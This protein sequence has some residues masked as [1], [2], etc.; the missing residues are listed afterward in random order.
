MALDRQAVSLSVAAATRSRLISGL[1]WRNAYTIR[2][3]EQIELAYGAL[4]VQ[5]ER[6]L[7]QA[8]VIAVLRVTH[9]RAYR[10][11]LSTG[12]HSQ[13]PLDDFLCLI[14]GKTAINRTPRGKMHPGGP[15]AYSLAASKELPIAGITKSG[16][17]KAVNMSAFMLIARLA[18]GQ[19][20]AHA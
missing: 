17:I 5:V 10:T 19:H 1:F 16:F 13:K 20:A 11:H 4:A 2:L 8:A 15:V 18:I 12:V 9:E 7:T 3:N 14:Y 6:R